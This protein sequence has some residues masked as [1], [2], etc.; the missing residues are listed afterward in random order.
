MMQIFKKTHEKKLEIATPISFSIDE[1]IDSLE[2]GFTFVI[3]DLFLY[4]ISADFKKINFHLIINGVCTAYLSFDTVDFSIIEEKS[5][6]P[7]YFS[8][9]K[10]NFDENFEELT[11][12]R[13]LITM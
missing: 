7:I 11:E 9:I 1:I 4:T 3:N 8:L 13:N 12:L 2:P 6:K 5:V 10:N